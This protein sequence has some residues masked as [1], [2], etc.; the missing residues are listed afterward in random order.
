[1]DTGTIQFNSLPLVQLLQLGNASGIIVNSDGTMQLQGS[2]LAMP[3][4]VETAI[5]TG[6]ITVAGATQSGNVNILGNQIA[7][8]KANIDAAGNAGGV[9]RI[10]S[11]EELERLAAVVS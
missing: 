4:T 1:M 7:L 5:A 2:T 11:V 6:D 10:D 3:T 8:V 9:V